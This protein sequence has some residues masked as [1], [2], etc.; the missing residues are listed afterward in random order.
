MR[1]RL[2]T[3]CVL[4]AVLTAI[5]LGGCGSREGSDIYTSAP[6][7]SSTASMPPPVAMPGG[8]RGFNVKPSALKPAGFNNKR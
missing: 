2:L 1:R 7:A 8:Q 6:P 4:P 3:A 5:L